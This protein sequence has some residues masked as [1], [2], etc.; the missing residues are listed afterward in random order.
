[1]SARLFLELGVLFVN[2]GAVV[3]RALIQRLV[4]S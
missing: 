2:K 4:D 1:M 3:D